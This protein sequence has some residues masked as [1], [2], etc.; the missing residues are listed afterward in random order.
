[1]HPEA[2]TLVRDLRAAPPPDPH[3]F[4]APVRQPTLP[5][6]PPF[7]FIDR[8]CHADAAAQL[9]VAERQINPADAVFA[10]HFP[11]RPVYPGSLLV[12]A[13]GQAVLALLTYVPAPC[14]PIPA[15]AATLT[16]VHDARFLQAV[17][18]ADCLHIEARVLDL[19]DLR[20]I[21]AARIFRG[22]TLCAIVILEM[23]NALA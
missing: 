2:A 4:R 3:F 6:R 15:S 16:R 11:D 7:L 13:A 10:G 17:G 22:S 12:E 21:G 9:L 5:H 1:M 20:L 19:D 8:V 23:F 18:P 14:W